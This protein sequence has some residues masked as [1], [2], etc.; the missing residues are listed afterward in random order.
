MLADA[1]SPKVVAAI[2]PRVVR[3]VKIDPVFLGSA[4]EVVSTLADPVSSERETALEPLDIH[5][6]CPLEIN[7]WFHCPSPILSEYVAKKA[8]TS[9][10]CFLQVRKLKR[11]TTFL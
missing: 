8:Q 2:A 11:V 9:A 4:G 6:A 1:V 7:R 3:R 5:P 10:P